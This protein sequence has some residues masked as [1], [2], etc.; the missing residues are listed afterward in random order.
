MKMKKNLLFVATAIIIPI[1]FIGLRR[2]SAPLFSVKEYQCV[3]DHNE[4]LSDDYF[5]SINNVLA[6]LCKER[7]AAHVII[8]RLKHDF[9][10]LKKV[11]V[12]YRPS[13][14]R[15]MISAH[16][17]KCCLNNSVILT[18]HKELLPKNVFTQDAVADVPSIEVAQNL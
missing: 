17:P 13:G 15:V 18:T 10:A 8:E 16:E 6:D 7:C 14:T 3:Q 1:I 2:N 5:S 9:P 4:F 11:V 12:A